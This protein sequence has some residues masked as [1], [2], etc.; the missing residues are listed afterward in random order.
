MREKIS[1]TELKR[2]E[3]ALRL[4]LNALVKAWPDASLPPHKVAMQVAHAI[5]N[6]KP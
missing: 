3:R 5:N 1:I 2:R 4:A 6:T